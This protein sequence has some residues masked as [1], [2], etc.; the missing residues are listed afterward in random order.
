MYPASD[1]QLSQETKD[2]VYFFS[3]AYDPLNNWSAHIVEIWGNKFPTVEH[4]FHYRKFSDTYPEIAAKVLNASSP[5]AAMQAAR[6]YKNE[7][8]PDWHEVKIGIMTEINRAK[9]IQNEDALECL[10]K[11]GNKKIVENS[12]WN[13]FWGCGENGKGKNMMGKILMQ[14]R[15]ELRTSPDH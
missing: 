7:V 5:W 8:R 15:E 6:K 3:H 12:P 1:K 9:F 10:L 11:T 13:S 14:I 2:T 4:A